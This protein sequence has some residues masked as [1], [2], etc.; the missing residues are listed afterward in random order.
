[1]CYCISPVLFSFLQAVSIHCR[2]IPGCRD[3]VRLGRWPR[4][5]SG[6]LRRFS[7]CT[8]RPPEHAFWNPWRSWS[9]GK[10]RA[11]Q[12]ALDPWRRRRRGLGTGVAAA[13]LSIALD[14]CDPVWISSRCS[15]LWPR[16][17]KMLGERDNHGHHHQGHMGA[18]C[19][20]AQNLAKGSTW[21]IQHSHYRLEGLLTGREGFF[22]IC[23]PDERTR[24]NSSENLII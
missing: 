2:V 6:L 22:V 17:W 11:P 12:G 14:I 20:E 19:R 16:P 8:E 4:K 3:G 15:Y 9:T 23:A 1:M 18:H 10:R 5:K 24:T 21:V 7:L 13:Y